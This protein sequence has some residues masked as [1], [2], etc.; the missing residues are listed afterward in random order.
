MTTQLPSPAGR[1]GRLARPAAAVAAIVA[2]M[3]LAACSGGSDA[4]ST[5]S[6]T[7]AAATSATSAANPQVVTLLKQGITQ[8]QNRQFDAAKTTFTNVLAI[9]PTNKYANYNLGLIAQTA[10]DTK[11]AIAYY[12]K[13]IGADANFTPALYNKAIAVEATKPDEAIS[14]YENIV[15]IN[16][17]A[18]TAFYR[19]SMAYARKGESQKASDARAKALALDPSLAK[20]S[21]TPSATSS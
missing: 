8:A 5:P 2:A 6:A 17:K 11:G 9:D 21:P 19:L 3:S 15:K 4:A 1:S 20:Q 10:N 12:D 13:A 14:M 7:P 18:S 16:P